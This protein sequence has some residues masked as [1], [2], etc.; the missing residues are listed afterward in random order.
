MTCYLIPNEEHPQN[1]HVCCCL[2]FVHSFHLRSFPDLKQTKMAKQW[3]NGWIN[4]T[5]TLVEGNKKLVT[6]YD[7]CDSL[8]EEYRK[9]SDTHTVTYNPLSRFSRSVLRYTAYK[10]IYWPCLVS[11]VSIYFVQEMLILSKDILIIQATYTYIS[12]ITFLKVNCKDINFC[13][14]TYIRYRKLLTS[15]VSEI[16]NILSMSR[17]CGKEKIYALTWNQTETQ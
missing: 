14:L 15:K 8:H 9:Y 17:C 16:Y 7:T 6:Q 4:R 10:L 12:A 11:Y 1:L 5:L 2:Y 13:M 3:N